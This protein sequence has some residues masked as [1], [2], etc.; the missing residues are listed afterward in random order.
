MGSRKTVLAVGCFDILH[1][2]H[3][4]HLENAKNGYRLLIVAVT[5]DRSVNKGPGRPVFRQE[6]REAMLKALRIVDSTLLVDSSLEALDRIRPAV[7]ALG[8]EYIGNVR[9]EDSEFCTKHGIQI[10]YTFG[11]VFSSTALL[12]HDRLRQG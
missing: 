12:Q 9:K 4:C 1:Y 5:R 11:P 7:F 8:A 3:L 6:Q 10:V 2:G